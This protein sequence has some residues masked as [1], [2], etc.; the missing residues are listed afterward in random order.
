MSFKLNSN[1]SFVATVLTVGKH[2]VRYFIKTK[3]RKRVQEQE[4]KQEEENSRRDTTTCES[5]P[6]QLG[7]LG[8]KCPTQNGVA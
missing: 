5:S 4:N 6:T 3:I 7:W 2:V 1:E 8:L